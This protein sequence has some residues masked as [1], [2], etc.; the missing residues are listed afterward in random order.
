MTPKEL[1]GIPKI[2]HQCW[3]G[4]EPMP[5][6]HNLW[7]ETIRYWNP[8][9]TF[10]LHTSPILW[11]SKD[12]L[13]TPALSTPAGLSNYIRLKV[14]QDYGGVYLDTDCECIKPLN[15][16]CWYPA[17]AGKQDEVAGEGYSFRIGT[18]VLGAEPDHPW[19]N[20]QLENFDFQNAWPGEPVILASKAVRY[21]YNLAV[22]PET[23]FYPFRWD[24]APAPPSDDT[25]VIHHWTKLW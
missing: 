20:W 21:G 10:F 3:F 6:T 15:S 17:F 5:A 24:E 9:W 19:I 23:Y 1:C 18:A 2:I 14:L 8:E 25:F 11:A 4:D 22:L 12:K 7:R 13:N 16:L